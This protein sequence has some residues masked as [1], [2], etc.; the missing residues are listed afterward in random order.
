[1]TLGA[2]LP[3]AAKSEIECKVLF[4][5]S[6]VYNYILQHT[7]SSKL[8]SHYKRW[9]LLMKN[10]F[11]GEGEL[12]CMPCTVGGAS[13]CQRTLP[14]NLSMDLFSNGFERFEHLLTCKSIPA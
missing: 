1:M 4:Y 5:D 7:C 6:Y 8:W 2:P 3:R 12:K 9:L 10:T 11:W 14:S 13:K